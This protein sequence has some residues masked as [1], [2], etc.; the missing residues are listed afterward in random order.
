MGKS[1]QNTKTPTELIDAIEYYFGMRFENDMAASSDNAQALNYYTEEEDSLSREWPLGWCWLNPPF[2]N[3]TKWINKCAIESKKCCKI[4]SIWPLSGDLNQMVTWKQA[5][6]YVVH[7]RV[8]PLVRGCMICEW[9]INT[10]GVVRGL[11]WA[12]GSLTREW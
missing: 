2:A 11:R 12:N 6:V 10:G 7:G 4:I 1:T 5:N 3:L 9:G 8:W